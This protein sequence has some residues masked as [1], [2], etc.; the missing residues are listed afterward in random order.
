MT[1]HD[2]KTNAISIRMFSTKTTGLIFTKILHDIMTLVALFN[3]AYTWRYSIPFLNAGMT[4]V[5]FAIFL[6]ARQT[7]WPGYIFYF[8]SFLLFLLGA[9]LSQYL[10]HR[11]SRSFHQMEGICVNFL[12]QVHFFRFLKGGCHGNQFCVVSKTQT[13]CD[14]CSFYT[15]WKR[16][17]CRWQ[18]WIFF[19]ISQ[20]TL[21]WQPI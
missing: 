1:N 19:P 14:F 5:Q 6:P 4:K 2:I 18:I 7:C 10:L 16:F 12:D 8:P 20:G 13:T 3:H 17:R 21:P 9:K 15:I 11:F